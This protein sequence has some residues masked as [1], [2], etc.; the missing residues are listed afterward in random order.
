[1]KRNYV[2]LGLTLITLSVANAASRY[3]LTL[4]APTKVGDANLAPG[5]YK[6]EMK[7]DVA[8]FMSGKTAT[9]VPASLETTKMKYQYNAVSADG[10]TM[11]EIQLG[12]TNTKIVI[13]PVTAV[14][15]N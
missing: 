7:G 5:E 8:V 10:S 2:L 12:G 1:M 11:K 3:S 14:A 9:E 6:V 4:T 15:G 13:K